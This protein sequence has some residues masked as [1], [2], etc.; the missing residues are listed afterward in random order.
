SIL[1]L[2]RRYSSLSLNSCVYSANKYIESIP[3]NGQKSHNSNEQ[4]NGQ[5]IIL[6]NLLF[7]CP[8]VIFRLVENMHT[9]MFNLTCTIIFSYC[10]IKHIRSRVSERGS[11]RGSSPSPKTRFPNHHKAA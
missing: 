3:Y 4:Y 1:R 10:H 2:L 6:K 7:F 9:F 5:K 8:P 11:C